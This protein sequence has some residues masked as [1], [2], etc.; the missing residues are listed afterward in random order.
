PAGQVQ[1]LYTQA[2]FLVDLAMQRC[3]QRFAEFDPAA[4][5]RIKPL[6]RRARAADQQNLAIAKDRGAD[7]ELGA[8]WWNDRVQGAIRMRCCFAPDHARLKSR[9]LIGK[10]PV[11]RFN[12]SDAFEIRPGVQAPCGSVG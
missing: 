2:G 10:A 4:R 12:L 7:G 6:A 1:N 5:E 3:M 11:K 8:G 9:G